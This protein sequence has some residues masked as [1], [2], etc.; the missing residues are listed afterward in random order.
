[1][2]TRTLL[3]A[4]AFITVTILAYID[5]FAIVTVISPYAQALGASGILLGLIVAGYSLAEDVF[6]AFVGYFIDRVKR[7]KL[8]LVIGLLLNS[9]VILMYIYAYDPGSLLGVRLIHGGLGALIGPA[10]MAMARYIRSPFKGL[11][12]RMGIY[13]LAIMTSTSIGFPMGGIMTKYFGRESLFTFLSTIIFFGAI[14]SMIL[15]SPEVGLGRREKLSV[16]DWVSRGFGILSDRVVFSALL[17]IF[18][19]SFI[20]GAITTLLPNISYLYVERGEVALS[21]YMGVTAVVA[22]FLQIPLGLVSDR[23]ERLKLIIFGIVMVMLGLILLVMA[24]TYIW[25]V[26][27]A[28][29]YGFGYAI[30]FPSTAASVLSRVSK[31]DTA[32]ASGLYHLMFT[33]GV[34]WGAIFSGLLYT[35][36]DPVNTL[37]LSII[38]ISISLVS[39]IQYIYSRESWVVG[40][41]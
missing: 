30:L 36:I 15:P 40:D 39:I 3:V 20:S 7:L 19:L 28:I 13:G 37:Y 25:L 8:I 26:A 41:V 33:E 38:P 34:V 4:L 35:A 9:M 32:Y 11:G 5:N 16:R 23:V 6:E 1:M 17:A 27:A 31:D 29:P 18:G 10:T 14:L 22:M 2:D 21:T 24:N 12:G